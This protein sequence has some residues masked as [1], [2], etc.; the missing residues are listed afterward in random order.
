[1][2]AIKYFIAILAVTVIGQAHAASYG[3]YY[4]EG[5]KEVAESRNDQFYLG[6][7][8][9]MNFATFKNEYT[10]ANGT[11]VPGA[12]SF[13]FATQLGLD[14]NVGWQF[15][16]KW[17]T[18][19][20]YGYTGTFSDNDA[21]YIFDMFAQY[22]ML[23][24]I[25]TIKEW[26]T[27]S[28]YAGIGA[29]AG[30]LRTSFTGPRFTSDAENAKTSIGFTGQFMLGVEE[31]IAGNLYLGL[32]YKLSYMTGHKQGIAMTDGDTFQSKLNG[33]LNNTLG[34]GLRYTF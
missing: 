5:F 27:T 7:R 2:K 1:M 14:V 15:A 8:F 33:I 26:T 22:L 31:K 9:D 24:G 11:E 17:R 30:M 16:P 4:S 12:D 20:N 29:G 25:Y 19:L 21:E 28:V 3:G 34:L 23:N 6:A 18:E 32:T 13:L 10:F